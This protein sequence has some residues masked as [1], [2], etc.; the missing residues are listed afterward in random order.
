VRPIAA[1]TRASPISRRETAAA[2]AA[3][4]G[5]DASSAGSAFSGK[6]RNLVFRPKMRSGQ[7][8][9][10]QEMPAPDLIRGGIRMSV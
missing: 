6:K 9:H 8:A 2:T 4:S 1:T 5:P 7:R 3:C 10:F